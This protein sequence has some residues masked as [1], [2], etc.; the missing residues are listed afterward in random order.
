[1]YNMPAKQMAVHV[2]GGTG[3]WGHDT[4]LRSSS[5]TCLR[6]RLPNYLLCF[7]LVSFPSFETA[8]HSSAWSVLVKLGLV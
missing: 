7:D 2:F 3:P 5:L 8:L 6:L 1:M 4:E